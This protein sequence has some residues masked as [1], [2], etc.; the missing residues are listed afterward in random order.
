M[1]RWFLFIITTLS[2][3]VCFAQGNAIA[4]FNTLSHNFNIL[5]EVDGKVNYDFVFINKGKTP[6][7]IKKVK[8]TCGCMSPDWTKHPVLPG[9]KG[10]IRATFDPTNRP[11][12][13]DKTITV[14]TN[15]KTPVHVL[16]IMGKVIPKKKTVLDNYPYELPSGLRMIYDHISFRA[17]KEGGKKTVEIPVYNNHGKD[18]K[19]DFM[20]LPS[21][22]KLK[23]IPDVLKDKSKGKIIAEYD[24]IIKNDIGLV[25]DVISYMANGHKEQMSVS[26]N[27][28]Q[29]FSGLTPSEKDAAPVIKVDK[30][31][32]NFG[33]ITKGE[34]LGFT[35]NICNT[36]K[37]DLCIKKLYSYNGEVEFSMPRKIIAP[38]ES[39]PVKLFVNTIKLVGTQKILLGIICNDPLNPEIKIRLSGFVN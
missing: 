39:L 9:N 3:F 5:K 25:K 32:M 37:S 2:S 23:M 33:N 1:I 6:I 19:I 14:Y 16:R 12:N 13:F 36:G 11:G 28:K 30:R 17:V 4:S 29:D 35:V 27:I 10:F 21:Y 38:N 20:N 15:A 22:I 7:I 18:L 31:Y 26:A 24:A 8:S 34:K